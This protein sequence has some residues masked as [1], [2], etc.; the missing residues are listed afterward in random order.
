[1][2]TNKLDKDSISSNIQELT[3]TIEAR[4]EEKQKKRQEKKKKA[5]EKEKRQLMERLA[6]PILLLFTLI[7][8][9]LVMVFAR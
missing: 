8:S 2:P 9:W 7:I 3:D 4:K 5:K 1:M 6:A